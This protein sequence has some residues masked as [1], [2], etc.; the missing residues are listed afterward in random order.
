MDVRGGFWGP[1]RDGMDR[2][3]RDG[4]HGCTVV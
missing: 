2:E 3:V 4:T 1:G